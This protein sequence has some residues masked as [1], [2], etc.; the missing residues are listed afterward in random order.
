MADM[1]LS[2]RTADRARKAEITVDDGQ[3]CGEVVQAAVENWTLPAD[4]QYSLT[5]VSKEPP[6]T[7]DPST[8]LVAAGVLPGETLEIQP[9]LVAGRG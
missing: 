3:S 4:S 2:L 5:N 9:V 7:L 6:I 8:D 1:E